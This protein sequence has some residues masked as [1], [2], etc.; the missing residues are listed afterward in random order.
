MR[1]NGR[2]LFNATSNTVTAAFGLAGINELNLDLSKDWSTEQSG[3][4][5][6]E[7]ITLAGLGIT[8]GT[9][10]WVLN[11]ASADTFVL[12]AGAGGGGGGGGGAVPEPSTA[13]VMGLL[14][15]VGLAGNRRRRRQESVA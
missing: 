2:K 12:N 8:A 6:F 4:M 5:T 1:W 3:S 9:Y 10:T 7:N 15:I 11:T 14:G 13:I